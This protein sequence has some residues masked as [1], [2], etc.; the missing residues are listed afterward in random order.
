MDVST[1][2][3]RN[4]AVG[5]VLALAF[6]GGMLVA[7]LGSDGRLSYT[8]PRGN[9]SLS[10]PRD[11]GAFTIAAAND[12]RAAP[13]FTFAGA[14]GRPLRLAD[15]QGR[16]VLVNL[17]A[18]WCPPCIAEM[19]DLDGVQQ[20]LG[21]DAFQVVAVSLDR[22]GLS[23]A[24]AWLERNDMR[25]LTPYAADVAQFGNAVLPTSLLLDRQGRVAWH[26]SG[27]RDWS[28]ADAQAAIQA[29]LAE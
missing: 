3:V 16:V 22:G 15:F 21:G 14:D 28:G 1:K 19:P 5:L 18:T 8:E 2:R 23:H 9:P 7:Y 24:K 11:A 27:M 4:A 29:V 12:R 17:W 20:R 10:P 13:G 25:A 26:G 6:G